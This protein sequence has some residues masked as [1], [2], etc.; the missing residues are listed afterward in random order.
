MGTHRIAAGHRPQRSQDPRDP[1][2]HDL[3]IHP[4]EQLAAA[5]T[6]A[7]AAAVLVER[8]RAE[9]AMAELRAHRDRTEL[10]LCR[11][12]WRLKHE[13]AVIYQMRDLGL[14]RD[15]ASQ[16]EDLTKE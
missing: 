10:A 13:D 11:L 15:T 14:W 12:S 9:V 3:P 7:E 6:R 2:T 5:I 1:M 16:S 8:Q 4:A